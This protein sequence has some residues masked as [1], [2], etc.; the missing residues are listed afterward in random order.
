MDSYSQIFSGKATVMVIMAHPDDLEVFCGGTV[1][2]LIADGKKVVSI[3]LTAG[4]RGSKDNSI[5]IGDLAKQRLKEDA[6]AMA[7]FGI[8]PEDSVNL[9]IN[10]G[11]VE[12][13]LD[14]IGKVAYQIRKFQPDLIITT[15]P[16]N[17]IIRHSP[18]TNWVN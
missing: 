12:N 9:M 5:S 11:E 18:G 7:V 16:E 8:A 6:T 2:R 13:S 15:N 17:V 4:N 10:D 14:I 3:K 1:A